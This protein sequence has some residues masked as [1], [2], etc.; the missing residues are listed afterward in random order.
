MSGAPAGGWGNGGEPPPRPR[1]DHAGGPFMPTPCDPML[2]HVLR[3]EALTRGLGDIEAKMLVEWLT[4]W[5]EL[6]AEASRTEDD[7]W[8]CVR[9]LCRRGRAISRFVQLWNEPQSRGGATQLAAAERPGR[10]G[11][12]APHPDV[13]KP[14]PGTLA[15]KS[16]TEPKSKFEEATEFGS[17]FEFGSVSNLFAFLN[18]REGTPPL[19]AERDVR[20]GGTPSRRV[21]PNAPATCRVRLLLGGAALC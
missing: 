13:G 3:D 4:D 19:R 7:A 21:V 8:S 20:P 9:R 18:R 11:P 16:E 2:R 12:D 14:T 15:R 1:A 10:A 6:L 5:T 17:N